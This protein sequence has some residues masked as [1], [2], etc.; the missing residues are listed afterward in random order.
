MKNILL[1]VETSRGFGRGV[2]KGI[3]NYA[4]EQSNWSIQFLDRSLHEEVPL[5]FKEWQGDGIISR[6]SSDSMARLLRRK[7]VPRVE[8][9]GDGHKVFS[10]VRACDVTMGK[11]A[12]TWFLSRG[13]VNFACFSCGRSWWSEKREKSFEKTLADAGHSCH[14]LPHVDSNESRFHPFWRYDMEKR[15]TQWLVRLPKPIGLWATAD[16]DAIQLHTICQKKGIRIPDEISLIGTSNDLLI[17]NIPRPNLSSIDTNAYRI[18]YQ[19]AELLNNRMNGASEGSL[20]II[21]P[22]IGIVERGS[23]DY[24]PIPDDDIHQALQII[25]KEAVNGLTVEELSRMLGLSR[26][27]LERN[28]IKWTGR[29]PKQEIIRLGIENAK[30]LL[31]E[32]S[33]TLTA[34]SFRCGFNSLRYFIAAF[35]RETGMTPSSYRS[36]MQLSNYENSIS[37]VV[38]TSSLLQDQVDRN[39]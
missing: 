9:L 32:S 30:R 28:F 14:L 17:C 2:I 29:T 34:I 13:F 39:R 36:F 22:P 35:R 31:R 20:P 37:D 23:T 26:R 7:E 16:D 8:L 1:L 38:Y 11:L 27:T 18:G 24:D 19:A 5:W 15:V 12:A 3:S 25:R 6:C 4:H 33:L 21:V 10:E